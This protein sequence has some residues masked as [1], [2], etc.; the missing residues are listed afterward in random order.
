VPGKRRRREPAPPPRLHRVGGVRLDV[1][2]AL[3]EH[4]EMAEVPPVYADYGSLSTLGI[5]EE[6][7]DKAKR[8]GE[9][10]PR[11]YHLRCRGMCGMH[12]SYPVF[13]HI[14]LDI[15]YS[16]HYQADINI[17]RN[18]MHCKDCLDS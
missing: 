1:G 3:D 2:P 6:V 16:P 10:A 18:Q 9:R 13:W 4:V 12:S 8:A 11:L 14:A 5:E 7:R 15:Y 17:N